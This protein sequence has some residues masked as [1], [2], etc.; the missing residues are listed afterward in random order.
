ML[1]KIKKWNW[2]GFFAI[3]CV[4]EIGALSNKSIPTITEALIVGL[5]FGILMGLPIAIIT[6]DE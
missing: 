2:G 4:A 6:K 3:L 1:N 5:I